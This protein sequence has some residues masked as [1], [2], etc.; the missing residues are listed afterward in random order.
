MSLLFEAIRIII[1]TRASERV[2]TFYFNLGQK[3]EVPG[4]LFDKRVGLTQDLYFMNF[5]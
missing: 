2:S 4:Y 3:I 5:F 1:I